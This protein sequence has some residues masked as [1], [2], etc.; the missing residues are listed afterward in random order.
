MP[1]V[2]TRLSLALR[3][4]ARAPQALVAPATA[5]RTLPVHPISDIT[6]DELKTSSPLMRVEGETTAP[7]LSFFVSAKRR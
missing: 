1:I 7:L 2:V 3:S 6:M 5:S 4:M